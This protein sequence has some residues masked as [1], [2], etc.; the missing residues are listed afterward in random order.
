MGLILKLCWWGLVWVGGEITVD[1]SYPDLSH[2]RLEQLW[3]G[4]TWH[5]RRRL[6]G[7]PARS[8]S[9]ACSSGSLCPP[10]GSSMWWWPSTSPEPR[11]CRPGCALSVDPDP[12]VAHTGQR[13]GGLR[14][15]VCGWPTEAFG[16]ILICGTQ[17]LPGMPVFTFTPGEHRRLPSS[18]SSEPSR[19]RGHLQPSS[20]IWL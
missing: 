18:L 15:P 20:G 7:R 6:Q 2:Y 14:S 3:A 17:A 1:E 10:A 13:G 5:R 4:V 12:G 16:R 19:G 11:T 9:S 8:Y